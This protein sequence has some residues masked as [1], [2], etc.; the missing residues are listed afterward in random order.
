[1]RQLCTRFTH[2][3]L[4]FLNAM[5]VGRGFA[6]SHDK[7]ACCAERPTPA[8]VRIAI[9]EQA[10]ILKPADVRKGKLNHARLR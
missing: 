3:R 10:R 4:I 7:A 5:N 6:K 9:A 8:I 1:M 2:G